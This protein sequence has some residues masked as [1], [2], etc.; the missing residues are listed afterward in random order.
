M[1][2]TRKPTV[3][4]AAFDGMGQDSRG[5]AGGIGYGGVPQDGVG[6]RA[7]T[8][9]M[10]LS[11]L[12][13]LKDETPV[14]EE[15]Q[16]GSIYAGVARLE[17]ATRQLCVAEQRGLSIWLS[18]HN[19]TLIGKELKVEK[20]RAEAMDKSGMAKEARAEL[21]GARHAR[22]A[23]EASEAG[24]INMLNGAVANLTATRQMLAERMLEG[25]EI[26]GG[27]PE[28]AGQSKTVLQSAEAVAGTVAS[29]ASSEGGKQKRCSVMTSPEVALKKSLKTA[30][31][32]SAGAAAVAAGI[33][34]AE[35]EDGAASTAASAAH[36][37][38]APKGPATNDVTAMLRARFARIITRQESL[39][40]ERRASVL[41]TSLARLD[42]QVVESE[43]SHLA[44]GKE[45]AAVKAEE[46]A[47]S[48]NI[49]RIKVR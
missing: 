29:T 47:E 32:V 49:K 2:T 31:T 39:V 1:G 20:S 42:T 17:D 37:E 44:D 6:Q 9:E 30:N 15:L 10:A 19:A 8:E 16:R 7:N 21:E 23:A 36:V 5:E 28:V 14:T 40:E 43:L 22:I 38:T 3:N 33:G 26:D 27:G 24:K 48:A 13:G 41:K 46:I 12:R 18:L 45:A 25:P 35:D 34:R 11:I 4:F